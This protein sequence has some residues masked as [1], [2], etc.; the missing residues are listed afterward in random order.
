MADLFEITFLRSNH[1]DTHPQTTIAFS[2]R[3]A[4]L[5]NDVILNALNDDPSANAV[6]GQF[7]L[8]K[9]DDPIAAKPYLERAVA[10]GVVD[11]DVLGDLV[12]TGVYSV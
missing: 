7:L 9:L 11:D 4:P 8:W 1:F 3:I 10:G 5:G 6:I 12:I 2:T